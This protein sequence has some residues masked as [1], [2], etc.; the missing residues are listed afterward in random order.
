M[1][2]FLRQSG[3]QHVPAAQDGRPHSWGLQMSLALCIKSQESSNRYLLTPSTTYSRSVPRLTTF[4]VE[5][6]RH[7]LFKTMTRQ[8]HFPR[9]KSYYILHNEGL[10]ASGIAVETR[11]LERSMG[12]EQSYG[13]SRDSLGIASEAAS[14]WHGEY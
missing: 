1:F 3:Y 6:L 10:G 12:F 5:K 14:S 9:L 8:L 2:R 11:Q 7:T 13:Q 4:Q